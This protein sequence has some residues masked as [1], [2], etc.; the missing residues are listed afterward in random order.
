MFRSRLFSQLLFWMLLVALIALYRVVG[1]THGHPTLGGWLA[2]IGELQSWVS[3]L[4]GAGAI[5]LSL[6][7]FTRYPFPR[8]LPVVLG[9]IILLGLFVAMGNYLLEWQLLPRLGHPHE[10][11]GGSVMDEIREHLLVSWVFVMLAFVFKQLRDHQ[12]SEALLHE[13]NAM[14][15]AYLRAQ[16]NPHFLFNSMNNLYGLA[17]TEPESTPDAILML[18]ELMRYILY[19]SNADQ[20]S[21][22]QEVDYLHSYI[23]LEKLRHESEFHLEFTIEGPLEGLQIAPLLL[24]CFVENAFKH[25]TVSNPAQPVRLHLAVRGHHISFSAHNQVVAQNKDQAGGVGLPGVRRRL[26]LLYPHRHR[27]AVEEAYGCFTCVLELEA[28]ASATPAPR[29]ALTPT[30][31][32]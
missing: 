26:A 5:S 13:K 6:W 4:T 7:V 9:Q 30:L 28:S 15:L 31:P 1:N 25:G 10:P 22:Q 32:A 27:L 18:A 14:E 11:L 29:P 17:L 16:L 19:E 2:A 21:L 24:I 3:V 8:Q 12:R 23:A 20:V